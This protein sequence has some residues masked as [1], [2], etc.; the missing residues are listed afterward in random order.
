[1]RRPSRRR[2][3]RA[4]IGRPGR[5]RCRPAPLAPLSRASSATIVSGRCPSPR[6]TPP[7]RRRRRRRPLPGTSP[8]RSRP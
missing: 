3:L 7:P 4:G 6:L 2:P 8:A 5:W 1:M